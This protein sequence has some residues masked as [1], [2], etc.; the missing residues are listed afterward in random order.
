MKRLYRCWLGLMILAPVLLLRE[1]G[2]VISRPSLQAAA[3]DE[4]APRPELS[5]QGTYRVL[6]LADLDAPD[7][8]K[9]ALRA[10][11]QREDAGSLRVEADE[12]PSLDT[13]RARLPRKQHGD[14]V[15][16]QRLP[17]PPSNLQ[18][19]VLGVAEVIGM[20]PSGVLDGLRS[21]GLTRFYR[22]P[23][24]GIVAF[25]ENNFLAA[26]TQIE[27]IAEAQNTRVNGTPAH[28]GKT[29]DSAGRSRVELAW[30]RGSKHYGL[31]AFGDA[32][33]D[34]QHNA[35]V[36]QEIAAAVRD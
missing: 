8:V 6:A 33:S 5:P 31:A 18:A 2:A 35:R 23:G 12:L 34:V 11:I 36:L 28:L 19:S 32:G 17:S 26:G 3:G 25:S 30:T 16:R 10:Q 4:G 7:V 24:V 9:Q 21:S 29:V 27:I 22:V 1:A 14:A 13:L 15:L 20:E